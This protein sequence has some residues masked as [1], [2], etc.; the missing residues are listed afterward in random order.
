[1]KILITGGTGFVGSFL[2]KELIKKGH[3][4]TVIGSCHRTSQ[5]KGGLRAVYADT[6]KKGQWQ[7]ELKAMDI[8]INLAGA[9]IF[10]RWTKTYKQQIYDSR[11]LTT[12]NVVEA[13]TGNRTQT[14]I[15]T[16][17]VGYYGSRGDDILT[18][19]EPVGCDFLA[20]VGKDWEYEALLAEGKNIRTIVGRFGVVMGK[21]GGALKQMV[22]PFKWFLGGH[23]GSGRQWFSWIHI[24]DIVNCMLFAIENQEFQGTANFCSPNPVTNHELSKILGD[25]LNKPAILPAPSFGLRLIL[26]E[27]ADTL[28]SSQRAVPDKLLKSGFVFKYP[29]LKDA[30]QNLLD[31]PQI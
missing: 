26:G 28:L 21:G 29:H 10:N 15:S 14:L 3:E 20:S 16:S 8:V 6:T 22:T 13:M 19:S 25:I 31:K 9:S 18:E 12:R 17:A 4:V 23:M 2:S 1:M 24:E 27:F 11:I 7:E 30:L 5:D